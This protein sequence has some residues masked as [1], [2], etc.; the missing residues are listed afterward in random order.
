MYCNLFGE[1]SKNINVCYVHIH[2]ILHHNCCRH[3]LVIW[4]LVVRDLTVVCYFHVQH[5]SDC[6]SD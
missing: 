3:I 1:L 4:H 2:F 6:S 5:Y